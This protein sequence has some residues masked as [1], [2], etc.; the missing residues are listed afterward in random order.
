MYI[1]HNRLLEIDVTSALDRLT[2]PA[3]NLPAFGNVVSK[4]TTV[5]TRAT[6]RLQIK[7]EE[8]PI[9]S[10]LLNE[11]LVVRTCRL[12]HEPVT[13]HRKL[14]SFVFVRCPLGLKKSI[15]LLRVIYMYVNA[16]SIGFVVVF[17]S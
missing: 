11:I 7:P 5:V 4:T 2:D 16:V 14:C 12:I 10:D 9:P 15:V 13:C 17:I 1:I 6:T 8:A 3:Y